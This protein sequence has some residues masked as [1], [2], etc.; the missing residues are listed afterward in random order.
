MMTFDQAEVNA[1]EAAARAEAEAAEREYRANLM[2][3]TYDSSYSY[4]VRQ[5]GVIL[6]LSYIS[7]TSLYTFLS[8]HAGPIPPTDCS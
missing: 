6:T 7:K 4:R 1:R 5:Q 3:V 2:A 8:A